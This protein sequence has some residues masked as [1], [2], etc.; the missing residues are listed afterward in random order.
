MY[1]HILKILFIG[2]TPG[3]VKQDDFGQGFQTKYLT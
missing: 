2:L 3:L 1:S